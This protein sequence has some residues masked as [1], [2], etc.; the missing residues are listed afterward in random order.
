MKRCLQEGLIGLAIIIFASGIA[1]ATTDLLTGAEIRAA[2]EEVQAIR[3]VFDRAEEALQKKNLSAMTAVY[4]KG[5]QNRGLR[6]EETVRIWQDIFSRYDSLSSRH[7]FSKIVVDRQ[8]GTAQVTCTGA[9]FGVSVLK[10]GGTAPPV[11]IDFWFEAVHHLTFEE[12]VWKI[13]G[14]DQDREG[15]NAFGSAIHLLF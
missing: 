5:Y 9:L 7:S 11:R 13:V 1:S 6:R 14:H 8:K 15:G 3:V 12:G 4:S 2:P 10:V